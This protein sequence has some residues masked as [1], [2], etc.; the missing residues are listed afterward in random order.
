VCDY[1]V[2]RLVEDASFVERSRGLPFNLKENITVLNI[3]NNPA[4]VEM[5]RCLLC[6][7]ERDTMGFNAIDMGIER[8]SQ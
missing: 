3:A 2:G 4:S 1:G 8:A 7:L 5:A 6:G